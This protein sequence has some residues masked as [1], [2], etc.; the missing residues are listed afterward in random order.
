MRSLR[1]VLMLACLG[2]PTFAQPV[3]PSLRE[4]IDPTRFDDGNRA[5]V[6]RVPHTPDPQRPT[7][8]Q[9]VKSRAYVRRGDN[10][11][12]LVEIV[13]RDGKVTDS[14]RAQRPQPRSGEAAPGTEGRYAIPYTKTLAGVRITDTASNAAIWVRLD[15]AIETFCQAQPEDVACDKVDLRAEIHPEGPSSETVAVGSSVTMA[16]RATFSNAFGETSGVSMSVAP[17]FVSPNL[18]VQAQGQT[19]FTEGRIDGSFR[20]IER[21][22]YTVSCKAA[23]AGRIFPQARIVATGGAAVVDTIPANNQ[24][25]TILDVLCT[26]S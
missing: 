20:R 14:W 18:D 25:N 21:I 2:G 4:Q 13:D 11:L 6:L 17:F 15:G 10:G 8:I 22:T 24:E 1:L 12:I 5:I 3:P 9:L 26:G 19:E 23:G 16:V 7:S